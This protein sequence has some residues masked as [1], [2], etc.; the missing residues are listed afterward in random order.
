MGFGINVS[1][2]IAGVFIATGQDVASVESCQSV[3]YL[4]VLSSA[5]M[6]SIGNNNFPKSLYCVL[7]WF[8]VATCMA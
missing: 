4:S 1:N 3:L 5:E 2:L 8:R 6:E 7:K